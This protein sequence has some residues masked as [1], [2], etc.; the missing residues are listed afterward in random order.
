MT[1]KK[2]SDD[3]TFRWVLK[4][5]V[6]FEKW[7]QYAE[8]WIK[9][10]DGGISVARRSITVFFKRYLYEQHL[11]KDPAKFLDTSFEA[12]DFFEICY[13]HSKSQ[14]TSAYDARKISSFIDWVL[15]NY[16]SVKTE[17]GETLVS[18]D[19]HNSIKKSIPIRKRKSSKP[20]GTA[21]RWI[22]ELDPDFVQWQ[23]YAEDWLKT[24]D[25]D[26]L[27][28][29]GSV[30]VFFKRYL[31]EQNITKDPAKFLSTS[32]EAPDFFEICYGHYNEQSKGPHSARKASSFIDWVLENYFAVED[33][34]GKKLVSEDYHNP[35]KKSIPARKNN[36]FKP[37]DTAFCWILELDPAFSEWQQYAEEW[38]KTMDIGIS[39]AKKSVADFFR[40]YLYEQH[41]TKDPVKFLSTSFEAPDFFEIC[42]GHRKDLSHRASDA[43]KTSLFIDW[44]LETYFS[45][46]TEDGKTQVFKDYH[47]PIK[48]SIPARKKIPFKHDD[49]TFSWILELDPD[50]ENWQQYVEEWMKTLDS[51]ISV[52]RTSITT[53]L[54]TYLYKQ[55]ITKDP[56]K[57]LSTSFEAPDFFEICYGHYSKLSNA[58]TSA[59][60][61]SSFIDW[62]LEN[63]FSIKTEDGKTLIFEDYH[64]PIKESIPKPTVY[65]TKR[66]DLSFHWILEL[67]S[68]FVQWQYYAEEWMKTIDTSIRVTRKSITLFFKR[69]LYEQRITKDPA[70]FLSTSFEVPDFF[71]I[72]YGHYSDTS[73]APTSA[74]KTSSF[75][76]WVLKTYFSVKTEDGEVLVSDD[77]HNPIKKSIPK[78]TV[79]FMKRNDLSF[80]WILELDSDFAQWQYY[81]EDWMKTIGTNKGVARKSVADFF[82]LYLYEQ[83]I[84]KDPAEFL[85]TSFEAPDFFEICYGHS[86][87]RSTSA[88]NAKKTSSFIDWVLENY[89]S[90]KAEDGITLVSEDYHNPIKKSIPLPKIHAMKGNDLSFRW[91]L[92]LDP[93]FEKW[94]QYVEEWMKTIGSGIEVAKHSIR[95]FFTSY[96]YEQNITKDPVKFLSTTFE[97]P[98]FFEICYGHYNEQSNGPSCAR[99]TSSFI[100]WVLENY[101]SVKTE[102]GETLVSEDYHNPIK[103]SIPLPKIHAMKRND[104]SLR[105]ILALDPDFEQWQHYAEN[106]F[107]TLNSGLSSARRSITVFFKCYLHEQQITKDPAKFL[108]IT[109]EAPDFFEICYG[110]SKHKS[111][112]ASEARK[113][114]SFIDWV[115]ENYFSVKTEDGETLV[116]EDYHNSIK[117]SI[118]IRKR[119]SSKPDGTAFRWILELDPDFVQWQQY[120]EDWLKTIDTDVLS[121]K[122][123]VTVFF[124][125]YL[126]EQN[127]TKDPA[128]FLSTSFE[129]PD[130]FEI[131]YGHSKHK[132]HSA[133]EAR[134]TSSFIDWVLENYLSVKDDNGETLVSDGY[135][136]PIKDS[137]PMRKRNSGKKNVTLFSW[138]LELDPDFEEWQQYVAEWM[139][140]IDIGVSMAQNSVADFF[141]R[142]LYEQRITKDPEKF[143]SVNYVAP[144]YFET[145]Y[146]HSKN[147]SKDT[148]R[149]H[150]SKARKLSSFIDWLLENHFPVTNDDDSGEKIT[151]EGYHNPIKDSIP[152]PKISFMKRNDLSFRWI[153]ELDPDFEEWQQYA[154]EWMKT[155]DSGI[156]VTKQSVSTFF[157]VYL[158]EQHITKDPAKFLSTSFKTPNF[159]NICYGHCKDRP[160]NSYF[161]RKTSS[162]I[163][164]V[165]ENYFS[166]KDVHGE[167]LISKGYHNPIKDSIPKPAILHMKRNDI[168]FRWILELDPD[169][170]RWQ[171]YAKKWCESKDTEY[172]KHDARISLFK[173][174]ENYLY[175]Q[176]ITKDPRVFLSKSF[177]APDFYKIC[178]NNY[179]E[180]STPISQSQNVSLFIDWV[181]ENYYSV[182]DEN[183]N[184]LIS[185]GYC[186]P[187]RKF[188]PIIQHFQKSDD[189]TFSWVLNLN[190]D[191]EEWRQYAEEW[192]KE[193]YTGLDTAIQAVNKFFEVYLYNQHITKD[194]RQFLNISFN[195][196]NYFELCFS[197]FKRSSAISLIKKTNVFIDW[198]LKNKFSFP[199]DFGR[200]RIPYEFH[201]P[202]KKFIPD[203]SSL[204]NINL[205]ESNKNVLP[206]RYI[207]NLRS[208]LCPDNA[209]NFSDWQY[210]QS[211]THSVQGGSW[212]RI[213]KSLIDKNDPDCVWKKRKPTVKERTNKGFNGW[214]YEIWSPAISVAL[215]MKL[216]LPLRTYQVRMLDSGEADTYIYQQ[217]KREEAGYWTKNNGPFKKGTNKHPSEK[218][219]FRYFKDPIT[220]QEMTGFF[221]N[222]NKT[223]DINKDADQKGYEIPWQNEEAL[224]WL[225]KLRNWQQKYNPL[226]KLASWTE[227]KRKHLG[228][229]KATR[230]LKQMGETAFLFRNIKSVNEEHLPM[231]ESV[232]KTLW[233]KLLIEL[234]NEINK[235]SESN[236][237]KEIKFVYQSSSQGNDTQTF[238]PLHALRVSLITAYALEGGV[239][240]PI[241]SKAIAGHARLIMTLY[242]TK[243][244]ISYVTDKMTEAENNILENDKESF[245]RFLRDAQYN[246]LETSSASND[247]IA[248]QAVINSQGS[249]ASIIKGDL[250]ICPK[251][252]FGCDS[253][254]VY[255][256]DDTGTTYYGPVPGYPEQNCVR[257]RWFITSPA[258]LPGL[259]HH[260]NVLSYNMSEA[261]KK[262]ISFEKE[263]HALEDFK[264][265]CDNNGHLFTKQ[266]KLLQLENLHSLEIQKN[267]KLAND[268][269]GTFYL[270]AKCMS[271]IEKSTQEENLQLITSGTLEDLQLSL[272]NA[273]DAL[274]QIQT[275]CNG[276][277]IFPSTDASKAI[278]QRSQIIDST[279][280]MNDKKPIMFLLTEKEQLLAGN[281]WMRLIMNRSGSLKDAIPFAV[282]RKKLEEIGMVLEFDE[283]IKSVKL[284]NNTLIL[285]QSN[286]KL[287][288][289]SEKT[290]TIF[291][292]AETI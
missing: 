180:S 45:V 96:L 231:T 277:E 129:A 232:I 142:Y 251:S 222:T 151:S 197:N 100:D 137:I 90:V 83:H 24:I 13:G 60:K 218:G 67:D 206:Y 233:L 291:K 10:L 198:V 43:R 246:Q 72:C 235:N 275:I 230:V 76:D 226:N 272:T 89:F 108:S 111:P 14:S 211:I 175:E 249:G 40:L 46:K 81:A 32:F 101:F 73:N 3:N 140:T 86:N 147:L 210:A 20:D 127:I 92:E 38:M 223:A 163:D 68:D 34:H 259:I 149:A 152:K 159:Y 165:L 237:E 212:I 133:S 153:L 139:K 166:D 269:N 162:F 193:Q 9:T 290:N 64:N 167:T 214:V 199:D 116:S 252:N 117:K 65:A 62:V 245:R 271:I 145:C 16:F 19:Y 227:L 17:D 270:I 128:K 115:L 69:F 57:F 97:A 106:W 239:P 103:K 191:F 125:R 26:V 30:T 23:Q 221:I 268:Y 105:W 114:S 215:Y 94:Q 225:A 169:F 82:N 172:E 120:A 136:N 224:Y 255:D 95:I 134:K 150:L 156:K 192:L 6:D 25:T 238:Y 87:S 177:E 107:R 53:F 278:L 18:E 241:L 203:N 289:D 257:C 168:S 279:L 124:K 113:T 285:D 66:N 228:G 281:Q 196:P 248:Y 195:A 234:E 242:Y 63:Y 80:R 161:A 54:K 148:Y 154:A 262:I 247:L 131:C 243:A 273:D 130:Y 12:L 201:N 283:E 56:A 157:K 208:M 288:P 8:A 126:Y 31:Y 84:T 207:K 219:A 261:G 183:G 104:L 22:L 123:S 47:N 229:V 220:K 5:D 109:F 282:G 189:R 181:L 85:S 186:N 118:P 44:V 51:G 185:G 158:Y 171:Q 37:D 256:N 33:D 184:V 119:K 50:F 78:P 292:E 49:S 236:E 173:F 155:I 48:K 11:T 52:A 287:L 258:F 174:F 71:E 274:E 112:S 164:W 55:H 202:I 190:S 250:G 216:L 188:I 182:K 110:H 41:I 178:Y 88:S 254:G 4:L 39:E 21:F 284:E 205:S 240:M 187:I 276:A 27:S 98:D 263:I 15:E 280:A 204:N 132:S 91:I 7:R 36:S 286:I 102:D 135:H 74:R 260:F 121:T 194:P 70:E 217:T 138:I 29:K 141:K 200:M 59:R 122:G 2:N 35:I 267:D 265:D 264:Y 1:N 209:T 79:Y 146:G 144:D 77:Y 179:K 266:A 244:G 213:D 28:T 143:L 61:T 160:I 99:K 58:P 176:H 170:E 93:D 253:G 75:I 42:Y